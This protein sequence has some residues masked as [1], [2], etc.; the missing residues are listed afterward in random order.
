MPQSI[1]VNQGKEKTSLVEIIVDCRHCDTLPPPF[2]FAYNSILALP[3]VDHGFLGLKLLHATAVHRR[4]PV[5]NVHK[6]QCLYL[7]FASSDRPFP[8]PFSESIPMQ[9]ELYEPYQPTPTLSGF[10]WGSAMRC[11][12]R[13]L[14]EGRRMRPGYLLLGLPPHKSTS[15]GC[16]LLWKVTIPS[17]QG[18]S[19]WFSFWLLVTTLGPHPFQPYFVRG[20]SKRSLYFI[21][22][23]ALTSHLCFQ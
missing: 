1:Q 10:C 4:H 11:T 16:I 9:T 15:V 20:I 8:L 21:D 3:H 2:F 6:T 18:S 23:K 14:Q 17:P 7:S 22:C 19:T 5:T 13:R 12:S